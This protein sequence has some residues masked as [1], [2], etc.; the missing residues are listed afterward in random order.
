MRECRRCREAATIWRLTGLTWAL[1]RGGRLHSGAS[2]KYE[3]TGPEEPQHQPRHPP[4]L[5]NVARD[6]CPNLFAWNYI[7]EPGAPAPLP[8]RVF[9]ALVVSGTRRLLLRVLRV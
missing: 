6:R 7:S 9:G 8:R 2:R 3:D 1:T 4:M 5:A